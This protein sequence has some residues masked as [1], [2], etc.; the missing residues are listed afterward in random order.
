MNPSSNIFFRWFFLFLSTMVEARR[1]CTAAIT[2]GKLLSRCPMNAKNKSVLSLASWM[3]SFNC[4]LVIGKSFLKTLVVYS[5]ASTKV[6]LTS[7]RK[8]TL[9]TSMR[10]SRGPRSH[11]SRYLKYS[12]TVSIDKAPSMCSK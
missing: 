7:Y 11:E 1:V 9:E 12:W 3:T 5:Q 8:Y 2:S 10:E 4:G 6:M